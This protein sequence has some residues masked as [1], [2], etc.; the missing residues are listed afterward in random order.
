MSLHRVTH[1]FVGLCEGR[2][3][4]KLYLRQRKRIKLV[5]YWKWLQVHWLPGQTV[6]PNWRL[7]LTITWCILCCKLTGVEAVLTL[8]MLPV[9]STKTHKTLKLYNTMNVFVKRNRHVRIHRSSDEVWLNVPA[10][11]TTLG[12][13]TNSYNSILI[14]GHSSKCG[15]VWFT[16][17]SAKKRINKTECQTQL[18][19]IIPSRVEM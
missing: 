10:N 1:C 6:C 13:I 17:N 11:I 5:N 12:R 3:N 4:A 2:L 7:L 16:G 8:C 18:S 9:G 14:S 19:I 15:P